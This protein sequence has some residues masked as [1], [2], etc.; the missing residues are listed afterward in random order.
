M[1]GLPRVSNKH[2]SIDIK[3]GKLSERYKDSIVAQRLKR[4]ITIIGKLRDDPRLK[5]TTMQDI[6][7]V[8]AILRSKRDV[9]KLRKEYINSP[10]FYQMIE[11]NACKDYIQNPK[12]SGY[13]GIHIIFKYKNKLNSSYDGLRIEMQIRTKLQHIWATA[14][15]VMGTFRGEKLKSGK[16]DEQWQ[17]LFSLVSSYFAYKK[18]SQPVFPD[19]SEIQ[20][21]QEIMK[22]E[23]EIGAIDI[24]KGFTIAAD[25]IYQSGRKFILSYRTGFP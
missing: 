7:G 24:M 5:L 4:Y 21:M 22:V 23:D 13:R 18:K 1:E 14:V 9:Y 6:G 17:R 20:T 2:V 12:A 3:R 15:E 8:R 16:G 10:H 11:V 25:K 19:L